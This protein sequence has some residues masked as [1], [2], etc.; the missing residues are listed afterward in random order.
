[1]DSFFASVSLA[2][3]LE[4]KYNAGF[5]GTVK[6]AHTG[7]PQKYLSSVVCEGKRG[8]NRVLIRKAEDG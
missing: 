4:S 6:T 1:M 5:V 7:F 3:E 2:A 8:E